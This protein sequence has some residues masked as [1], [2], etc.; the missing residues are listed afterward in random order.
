M[1]WLVLL[2]LSFKCFAFGI[3]PVTVEIGASGS[4]AQQKFVVSNQFETPLQVEVVPLQLEWKDGAYHAVPADEDILILP[5]TAMIQP[6]SSQAVMVRYLGEPDLSRSKAY[7]IQFN[8]VMTEN[9]QTEQTDGSLVSMAV[10]Y[11]AVVTVAP[12]KAISDLQLASAKSLGNGKWEVLI[13]NA[14]NK[15]GW[16]TKADWVIQTDK[17]PVTIPGKEIANH[18]DA[19]FFP[20]LSSTKT[21]FKLNKDIVISKQLSLEVKNTN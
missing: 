19:T 15:H 1:R 4:K 2:L 5:D 11:D 16:A 9:S 20:P 21:T 3:M 10:S 8:Q 17:G 13:E 18:I 6:G 14:G 7:V 12:N